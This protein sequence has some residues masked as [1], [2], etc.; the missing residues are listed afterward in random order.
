MKFFETQMFNSLF[1]QTV[2]ESQLAK[3]ASRLIAMNRAEDNV[4]S[5][6]TKLN[7]AKLR[8]MHETRNKKQINTMQA[9]FAQV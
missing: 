8:T 1:E 3:Y 9:I 2:Y 4:K 5:Q 7:F 6:L